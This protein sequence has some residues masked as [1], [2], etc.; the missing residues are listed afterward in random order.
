M[1][2]I[3]NYKLSEEFFIAEK[4]SDVFMEVEFEYGAQKWIGL[5]PK[6]LKFQGLDLTE[7]EFFN[8]IEESYSQLNPANKNKWI[9]ESDAKWTENQKQTQTYNHCKENQGRHL[10]L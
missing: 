3:K 10:Q 4:T 9:T 5:L 8:S 2:K 7:E 6:F 1:A